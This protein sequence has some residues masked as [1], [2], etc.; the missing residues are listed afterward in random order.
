MTA[1]VTKFVA[2]GLTG[3]PAGVNISKFVGYVL[4]VPG[5]E[6]GV[7]PPVTHAHSYAQILNKPNPVGAR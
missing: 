7:T 5:T 1:Q 6:T 4:L 2:Y 3:K